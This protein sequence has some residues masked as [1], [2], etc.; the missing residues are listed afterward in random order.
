MLLEKSENSLELS[1]KQLVI[2]SSYASSTSQSRLCLVC[3]KPN[4]NVVCSKVRYFSYLTRVILVTVVQ[5]FSCQ[6]FQ[7]TCM[8]IKNIVSWSLPFHGNGVI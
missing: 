7:Q 4:V 2:Q 1:V 6:L 5:V 8:K 3:E